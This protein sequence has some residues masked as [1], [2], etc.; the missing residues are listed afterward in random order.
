MTGPSATGSE[1]GIPSSMRSAP[2]RSKATTSS[3]VFSSEG[4]P[5]MTQVIKAFSE[6]SE[7]DFNVDE[8]LDMRPVSN[9]AS[10]RP[11]QERL[12][13]LDVLIAPAGQINDGDLI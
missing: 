1:K 9:A 4:S 10:E 12:D 5:A 6:R 8:I 7:R 3:S 13:L 2:A 11:A